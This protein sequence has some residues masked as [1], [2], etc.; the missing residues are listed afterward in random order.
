MSP[1]ENLKCSLKNGLEY[2]CW[3]ELSITRC[4]AYW[5]IQLRSERNIHE[6]K[7]LDHESATSLNIVYWYQKPP[8]EQEECCCRIQITT[9]HHLKSISFLMTSRR[10][11][12]IQNILLFF[13]RIY[14][15]E[16]HFE[17]R[18]INT[19][20]KN[21]RDIK[22]D[23]L[24]VLGWANEMRIDGTGKPFHS[25]RLHTLLDVTSPFISHCR[26]HTLSAFSQKMLLNCRYKLWLQLTN[27]ARLNCIQ[28][29]NSS[30]GWWLSYV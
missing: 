29:F 3:W 12:E 13:L 8:H 5:R 27:C 6:A 2:G 4:R 14:L 17:Y 20:R 10:T 9:S 25:S 22:C 21:H 7:S 11:L 28:S 23:S 30:Y 15:D 24:W 1:E 18:K 19:S 26:D 16:F